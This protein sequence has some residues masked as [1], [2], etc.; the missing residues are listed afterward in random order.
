MFGKLS[1]VCLFLDRFKNVKATATLVSA[2]AHDS[3]TY[4]GLGISSLWSPSY[5]IE[6]LFLIIVIRISIYTDCQS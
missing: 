5:K 4:H 1:T 3:W 2:P 6:H